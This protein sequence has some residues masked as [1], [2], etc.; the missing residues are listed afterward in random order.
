M[1]RKKADKRQTRG[2]VIRATEEQD[3]PSVWITQLKDSV[4]FGV[5]VSGP[6]TKRAVAKAKEHFTAVKHFVDVEIP[7]LTA[8]NLRDAMKV[9]VE[10][11]TEKK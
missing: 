5:R 6:L 1:A 7:Q 11:A 9:S 3:E 8:N 4:N 2:M 10:D